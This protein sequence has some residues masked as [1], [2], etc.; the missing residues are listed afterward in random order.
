M[1]AILG[2]RRSSDM[3]TPQTHKQAQNT[4]FFQVGESIL[5]YAIKNIKP[6]QELLAWYGKHTKQIIRQH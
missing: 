1:A 5:A 6:H 4:S 3:L 2:A